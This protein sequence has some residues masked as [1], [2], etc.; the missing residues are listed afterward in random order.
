MPSSVLFIPKRRIIEADRFVRSG[1]WGKETALPSRRVGVSKVGIVGLG[2]IGALVAKRMQ[3]LELEV[4]YHTPTR[5]PESGHLYFD[6]IAKLAAW[7]DV[8]VLC[9]P[10]TPAT[11]QLVGRKVLEAL[12][13]EGM[14]INISRGSVVAED[15]LIQ[16]LSK[17]VIA[18]A[19]LDVFASEPALDSRLTTLRNIILSPHAAAVTIETRTDMAELLYH[20]AKCYFSSCKNPLQD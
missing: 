3:A 19:A 7:S 13:S 12:G 1:L 9:C 11:D 14:L 2:K 16:A 18:T 5:K 8:L 6:H 4:G 20:R 10:A 17:G 15:E